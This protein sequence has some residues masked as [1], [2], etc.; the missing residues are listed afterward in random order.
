MAKKKATGGVRLQRMLHKIDGGGQWIDT[1]NQRVDDIAGTIKARI[2]S[3]C[4]YFVSDEYGENDSR[5]NPNPK[6]ARDMQKGL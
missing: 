3:N 2:N 6:G 1:Y 4:M 5:S